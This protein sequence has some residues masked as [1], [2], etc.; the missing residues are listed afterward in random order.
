M[1]FAHLLKDKEFS[2]EATYY[3]GLAAKELK[4]TTEFKEAMLKVATHGKNKE[5]KTLAIDQSPNTSD[6]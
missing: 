1:A 6:I 2:F 4:L 3:F 5:L